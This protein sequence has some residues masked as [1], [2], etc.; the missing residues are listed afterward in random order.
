[1]RLNNPIERAFALAKSGECRD[2]RELEQ[3]LRREGFVEVIQHLKGP[4]IRRDSVGMQE[5][6]KPTATERKHFG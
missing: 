1:L 6:T 2:I 3:K 5:V 4:S